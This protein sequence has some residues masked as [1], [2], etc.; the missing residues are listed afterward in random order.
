MLRRWLWLKWNTTR[1]LLGRRRQPRIEPLED[2]FLLNAATPAVNVQSLYQS[3][4]LS[5]EA[6]QGQFA[7]A[8]QYSSSGPG[9]TV[10][11][12]SASAYLS[13]QKDQT[14]GT[15]PPALVQMQLLNA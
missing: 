10:F 1:A 6:N 9:Y 3:L 11:L 15:T 8:V 14:T 2:R 7:P 12:T 5:F 4:P 13:L